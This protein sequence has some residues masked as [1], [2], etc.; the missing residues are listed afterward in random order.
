[1][2]HAILDDR[3]V[4]AYLEPGCAARQANCATI[5]G[6]ATVASVTPDKT[7][8]AYNLGVE[9]F[10]SYFADKGKYQTH[11]NT[12]GRSNNRIVPGLAADK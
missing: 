6:T 12:I 7:E 10:H 5:R 9:G 2:T 11:E 1:L 8:A 4:V 3:N